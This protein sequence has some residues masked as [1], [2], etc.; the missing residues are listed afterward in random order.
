MIKFLIKG[1]SRDRSRSLFPILMVSTG[2]FLTVVLYGWI[3][4]AMNDIIDSSARF[5]T[6]HIK[7][8]TQAY[9][10]L[11]DQVPNDLAILGVSNLLG[12]LRS[13]ENNILWTPRI[14]FGGLLDIPDSLG[15]TRS[16]GP[17]M[18]LG[19]DFSS[20]SNDKNILNIEK[21]LVTGHLPQ[22]K[23][24][25]LI[26][27]DFSNKLGVKI[28][29]SATLVSSTMN[30]SMAMYNFKICGIVRFGVTAMDR[31]AVIGDI[32]GIRD[33]LD[34]PDGASEILGYSKD[35]LYNEAEMTK[36]AQKFNKKYFKKTDEFS[37]VMLTLSEQNGL[38]EYI[39][40]IDFFGTILVMIFVVAMSI[41]LWNAGL[42][43]ALRRYGE[44]GL[45]LAMGESKGILY[46]RMIL[47]SVFIGLA[48]SLL[49]TFFGLILSYY[50][51]YHGFDIT[52]MMQKS[53][54]VMSNIIRARVSLTSYY[55]GFLPG[56]FASVI[57]TMFAGIGIYKRKTSQLF[58]ELEI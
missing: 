38:K 20:E 49:G 46:G 23:N 25:L 51:Q 44:I 9:K 5:D 26:S 1:L 45:R 48:G 34:M 7:V 27:E 16:Q 29:E 36:L 28:G 54:M 11:S 21:A 30:G 32:N 40:I 58:K 13:E 31:G 42:M 12:E 53:T 52:S 39:V 4:G 50:L 56:L 6:G 57:G 43:N 8:M 15:E 24:E 55:I 35:M 3:K 41:V 33:A 37:P 19:V 2:A 14:R 47:E 18:G 10:E 17:V 22:K